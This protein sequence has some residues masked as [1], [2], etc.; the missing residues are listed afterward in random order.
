MNGSIH[1]LAPELQLVLERKHTKTDTDHR[2]KNGKLTSKGFIFTYWF[3]M[4]VIND[5]LLLFYSSKTSK[6]GQKC[7]MLYRKVSKTIVFKNVL[8]K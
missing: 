5:L 4:K 7:L 2:L 6:N 8:V 1:G 3:Y